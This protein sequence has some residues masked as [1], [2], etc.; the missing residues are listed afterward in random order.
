MS[1]CGVRWDQARAGRRE[2][3]DKD[4]MSQ[5]SEGEQ[6]KQNVPVNH[7][8]PFSLNPRVGTKS[9]EMRARRGWLVFF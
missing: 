1:Y 5:W 8:A 7:G 3:V 2:E 4:R 9:G 6:G